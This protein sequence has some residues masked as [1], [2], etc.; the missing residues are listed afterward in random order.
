VRG[1]RTGTACARE[2]GS[3]ARHSLIVF[4]KRRGVE[5]KIS[6]AMQSQLFFWSSCACMRANVPGFS[7]LKKERAVARMKSCD[8]AGALSCRAWQTHSVACDDIACAAERAS[9]RPLAA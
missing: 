1:P 2:T 7:I 3:G 9:A 6:C 4:P 5:I 8:V